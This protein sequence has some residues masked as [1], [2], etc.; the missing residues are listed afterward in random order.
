[1]IGA[2]ALLGAGDSAFPSLAAAKIQQLSVYIRGEE[3]K[4]GQFL[5]DTLPELETSGDKYYIHK[6]EY[7]NERVKWDRRDTPEFMLEIYYDS[8]YKLMAD[9]VH[10]IKIKGMDCTYERA[11]WISKD[12]MDEESGVRGVRIHLKL[13]A[14]S[15]PGASAGQ[16]MAEIEKE[17][18]EAEAKSKKKAAMI[19][20]TEVA[21]GWYKDC[22][23][24]WY[25]ESDGTYHTSEWKGS[26]SAGWS[27][28]DADGY[29]ATGWFEVGDKWYFSD[30]NGSLLTNTVAP[31]GYRVDD[32]GAWVR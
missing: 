12:E 14:F 23:G 7:A 11:E 26:D 19:R 31:D 18:A 9:T 2:A 5:D 32:S 30:E 24:W 28:L 4:P 8:E 16:R 20:N 13:P 21:D 25:L 22:F 10:K 27:Y 6:Y 15:T 17:A 3:P 29:A 1:M